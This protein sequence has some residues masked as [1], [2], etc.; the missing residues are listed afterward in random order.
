MSLPLA[1][2]MT[3]TRYR[4]LASLPAR[5][6]CRRPKKPTFCKALDEVLRSVFDNTPVV[7]WIHRYGKVPHTRLLNMGVEIICALGQY[8][9]PATHKGEGSPRVKPSF[10]IVTYIINRESLRFSAAT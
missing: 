8:F 2:R 5:Y 6:L 7:Q 3:D 1:K 10:A 9:P 4:M